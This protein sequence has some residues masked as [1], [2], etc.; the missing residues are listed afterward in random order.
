MSLNSRFAIRVLFS[1]FTIATVLACQHSEEVELAKV[2]KGQLDLRK[3]N[4]SSHQIASLEGDWRVEVVERHTI[5][6]FSS[7]EFIELPSVWNVGKNKDRFPVNGVLAYRMHVELPKDS[8]VLAIDMPLVYC[9]YELY[10]NNQLLI[11]SGQIGFSEDEEHARI[12]PQYIELPTGL[13]SFDITILHSAY[14]FRTGGFWG[15]ISI[16]RISYIANQYNRTAMLEFSIFGFLAVMSL[17]HLVLFVLRPKEKSTLYFSLLCI[18]YLL[19][20]LV[21]NEF[22]ILNIF[23]E[24]SYSFVIA[25]DYISMPLVLFSIVLFLKTIFPE[26]VKKWFYQPVVIISIAYFLLIVF[27]PVKFYSKTIIYFELVIGLSGLIVIG[28]LI[29]AAYTKLQGAKMLLGGVLLLIVA[30]VNDALVNNAIIT[31]VYLTAISFCVFFFSQAVLLSIRFSAAFKQSEELGIDLTET[32]IAYSRFVPKTFLD[33]LGHSD[34]KQIKLGDQVQKEMTILFSDI[35]SFTTLSENMTPQD[36][37]NFLNSYLKRM[38]PIIRNNEGFIDK[39]IGDAIMA[40]FP[41]SGED[42]LRAAIGIIAELQEYNKHRIENNSEPVNI[43]IGVHTGSLILGT[44]GSDDRMDGT[45]ISDS[46]N[47]ASRIEGLT[48]FYG[49]NIIVS[50]ATLK[51]VLNTSDYV[52]RMLDRVIVQGKSDSVAVFE[53]FNGLPQKQIELRNKTKN[54]FEQGIRLYSTREFQQAKE[55]FEQVCFMDS[56]DNAAKIYC[57]RCNYYIQHGVPESWQAITNMEVK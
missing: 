9:A 23:P 45:V 21:S 39:Y 22:V 4:W 10:I 42:G 57:E 33:H 55:K 26:V 8:P 35:R 16:G 1:A 56:S 11:Q 47:L 46:V 18:G 50:E 31:S 6:D 44:I 20:V 7:D 30:F 5:P 52:F 19:R 51:T 15:P 3:W 43:G 49:T 27:S 17:Y 53:V 36:N 13:T 48:K 12:K 41:R 40:L 34:I 28:M 29:R 37:F 25:L 54:L 2:E 14:H 38:S 24:L 32:N